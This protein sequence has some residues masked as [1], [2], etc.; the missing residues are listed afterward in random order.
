MIPRS[1]FSKAVVGDPKNEDIIEDSESINSEED[2]SE[3]VV[4]DGKEWDEK[5]LSPSRK[6]IDKSY[7]YTAAN[8]LNYD[9]IGTIPEYYND[10]ILIMFKI[11]TDGKIPFLE[12][13][14]NYD[15]MTG[16]CDF[17]RIPKEQLPELT[18]SFKTNIGYMLN[19]KKAYIFA[20]PTSIRYYILKIRLYC[21]RDDTGIR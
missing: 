3:S 13:G 11:N 1:V 18:S 9:G 15:I 20:I 21:L 19:H 17:M 2:S 7:L 5:S 14:M 6:I 4:T 16:E 8:M 10:I 12:F